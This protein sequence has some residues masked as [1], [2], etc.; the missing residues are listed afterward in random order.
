MN[1]SEEENVSKQQHRVIK[2]CCIL[3][4]DALNA[5]SLKV[6]IALQEG[7]SNSATV[8]W[9]QYRNQ[10]LKSHCHWDR[11]LIRVATAIPSTLDTFYSGW[12]TRLSLLRSLITPSLCMPGQILVTCQFG[13]WLFFVCLLI[14]T[15]EQEYLFFI[16]LCSP[17]FQ[18]IIH[19]LKDQNQLHLI[20]VTV[21]TP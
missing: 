20:Q 15:C 11:N 12:D 5:S 18:R 7:Y 2:H 9:G 19:P 3:L 6:L 21:L 17:I 1:I 4:R 14:F 16:S 8:Q 13:N 10:R